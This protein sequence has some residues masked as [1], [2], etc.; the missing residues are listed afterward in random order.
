MPPLRLAL[1]GLSSTAQT[2]WASSAH[3]PYLLSARGRALFTVVAL[4]NSSES[5]ARAAIAAYGLPPATKAYGSPDALAADPDVDVVVCNTRVDVH[6]PSVAPS[7]R[8]GKRVWVEWPLAEG[9]GAAR[10]LVE[11]V[12]PG[13]LRGTVVGLQGRVAGVVGRVGG[14]VAEGRVGRVLSSEVRVFGGTNDREV[15]PGGLEYF[16]RREV[17]GNPYTIG[18]AHIFDTVQHVLGDILPDPAT[19]KATGGHFQI[20]RP[21]VRILAPDGTVSHTARTDVPDLIYV[22]GTLPESATVQRGATLHM[23]LR[24]GQPYPGEPAFV[25]TIHGEKGE[26]KVVSQVVSFIQV[27]SDDHPATLEVHDF[28]TDKVE[29]VEWEYEDWQKELPVAARNVGALYEAFAAAQD[30]GEVRYAT[31]EDAY[32]RHKQ[33]DELLEGFRG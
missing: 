13:G 24:R 10:G 8:A 30:G 1:I 5:A 11:A 28:E 27:G 33:L 32:Q 6:A 9:A 7:V 2:S 3:L 29:K 25:W 20:Q 17:G 21:E 16:T 31:F 18:F 12:P 14:L 19:G 22:T 26:I 4:L 23:R 15:L